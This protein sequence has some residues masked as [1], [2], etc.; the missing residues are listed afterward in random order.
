MGAA[1]RGQLVHA[2]EGNF[3]G[4]NIV[5]ICQLIRGDRKHQRREMYHHVLKYCHLRHSRTSVILAIAS[6]LTDRTSICAYGQSHSQPTHGRLHH[7]WEC[8]CP[9]EL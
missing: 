7:Q 5:L 4:N 2:P 3:G 8:M 6:L 1:A 9:A